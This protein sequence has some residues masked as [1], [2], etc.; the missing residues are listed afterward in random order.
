MRQNSD[1][2]I[3]EKYESIGSPMRTAEYSGGNG[4]GGKRGTQSARIVVPHLGLY[5]GIVPVLAPV[6]TATFPVRSM[7]TVTSSA[8][9]RYPNP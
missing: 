4:G 2:L 9:E 6:T 5:S 3:E 8:V 1:E 7:P